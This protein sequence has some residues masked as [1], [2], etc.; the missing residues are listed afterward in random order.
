[1][2]S[3]PEFVDKAVE[4]LAYLQQGTKRAAKRR[5]RGGDPG[6]AVPKPKATNAATVWPTMTGFQV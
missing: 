3:Q 6:N 5:G 4:V 2:C 1:L